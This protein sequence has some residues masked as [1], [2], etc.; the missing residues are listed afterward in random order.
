MVRNFTTFVVFILLVIVTFGCRNEQQKNV[1]CL[2]QNPPKKLFRTLA[3]SLSK[4]YQAVQ[5]G[6]LDREQSMVKKSRTK[7]FIN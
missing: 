7:Y 2:L 5:L 4:V 1:K 6:R 3:H